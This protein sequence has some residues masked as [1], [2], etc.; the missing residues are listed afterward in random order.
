MTPDQMIE[1]LHQYGQDAGSD[2]N[3]GDLMGWFA[4]TVQD[5]VLTV[6]YEPATEDGDPGPKQTGSWRLVHLSPSDTG[7]RA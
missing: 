1:N 6:T 3:D 5:G 4:W 2:F 7:D